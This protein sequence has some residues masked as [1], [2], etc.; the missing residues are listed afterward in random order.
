MSKS[1]IE[2]SPESHFSIQN[3][4]F[5]IFSTQ[6][7][8]TPRVGTAI[9][10]YAVDLKALAH[11]GLFD[12]VPEIAA[13]AKDIFSKSTLNLF[14]AQG[15]PVWTATRKFIQSI[16]SSENSIL[17]DNQALRTSVF[18]PLNQVKMHMPAE[19]GDYTDFYASKEHA[20]NVGIMFRGKDNALQPNWKHL[21]VGYHGRASSVVVSGTDIR[22]PCG[23]KSPGKDQPP[24]FGVCARLDIELEMAFLVGTGNEL[25]SNIPIEKAEEHIFRRCTRDIQ[26]WEYVPLGP[27]LGKSFGTTIS[28]WVVT[29]DALKPFA[30]A[31]PKQDPTPLPYLQSNSDDAYD[32]SLEVHLKPNGSSDYSTISKSNLKYMYWSFRQMLAHHTVNGCNARA[33][34]LCGTGTISGPTEDSYGSMLEMTWSGQKEI[35]L[36]SGIKRKFLEDGDEVNLIGFCQGEG[37]RVGFGDCVGKITPASSI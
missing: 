12:Q 36:N 27:F 16:L 33:G 2:V 14:M 25:G 30:L 19:I 6:S 3:I 35:S 29:L 37:Y 22:R 23:Q 1:F 32:I 31:Q 28:P 5:G 26:A 20:T 17:R 34:D 15:K 9:G 10:D 7:E 8:P 11:A 21:P 4:P 24:V 18:V 13:K